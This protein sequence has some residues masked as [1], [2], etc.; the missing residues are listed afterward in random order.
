MKCKFYRLYVRNSTSELLRISH[1][2]DKLQRLHSFLAWR[3]RQF[4]WLCFV[5]LIRFSYWSKCHVNIIL[6]LWQFSFHKGLTRNQ[7][8][9]KTLVWV[10]PNIWILGQ[11]MD[12]KFGV[13]V[14]NDM[15]LNAAKF[16]GFSFYRCDVKGK[17]IGGGKITPHPLRL[18]LN[19]YNPSQNIWSTTLIIFSWLSA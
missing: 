3:R 18:E 19:Y 8:I 14:S 16:Q 5:S 17:P 2:L 1:K 7:E 10:L 11:V 15:L 4:F 9:R 12:T 6:E 13:N